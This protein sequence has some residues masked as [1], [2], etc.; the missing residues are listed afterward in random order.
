VISTHEEVL[1]PWQLLIFPLLPALAVSV[2][3]RVAAARKVGIV[4]ICYIVGIF[5]GNIGFFPESAQPYQENLADA[6]VAFALPLLL[7]TLDVRRWFS[8]A[9]K[10][11]VSMA[12]ACFAAVIMSMLGTLLT[13]SMMEDSWKV[14]GMA[15]AVYTGGT[16]N[17]AALRAALNVDMDTFV[18]FH[19]YDTV[20]SIGYIIFCLSLAQ[21][22]FGKWLRP[23]SENAPEDVVVSQEEEGTED[24]AAFKGL[25]KPGSWPPL[26]LL[27][28]LS[29]AIVLGGLWISSF[30]SET[31]APAIAIVVITS[32][33]IGASLITPVR[34]TKYA[35]QWGMYVIYLF[36]CVVGSMVDARVLTHIHYPIL[37]FVALAVFGSMGLHALLCRLLR[38][39]VDTFIITSVAAICSPPFVPPVAA[40]LKNRHMLLS[41]ITM[42]II[43]YAVGNYLGIFVAYFMRAVL[44]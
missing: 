33:G 8:L 6:A 19:T 15:T 31:A 39:D 24:I 14:G 44:T 43:G 26:F 23:F 3:L 29:G 13:H 40:A 4:L 1:L 11:L 28:L 12:A 9:G 27:S 18:I 5:L 36:C 34:N 2:C 41:G 21:R 16:P 25:L 30:F 38:V 22:F 7:F 32:L 35:F 17:V 42:G 10:A 20:I 37:F